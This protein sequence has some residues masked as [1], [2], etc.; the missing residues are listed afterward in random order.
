VIKRRKAQ[1]RHPKASSNQPI[2]CAT[3]RE[4]FRVSLL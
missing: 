3:L 1:L 2:E 4:L